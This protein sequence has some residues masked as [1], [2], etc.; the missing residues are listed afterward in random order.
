MEEILL[1]DPGTYPTNEVLENALGED[2]YKVFDKF[3]EIITESDL[4][5]TPEW[6]YYN[7]GKAWLC[8]VGFKKK[9]MFWLSIWK[10]HFKL[11]FYFTENNRSG[12]NELNIDPSIKEEF[13]QS[14]NIGKLIPLEIKMS[15]AE[16]IEDVIKIIGYKKSLK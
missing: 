11:G 6:K 3:I 7:D 14:K 5:L 8:K 10:M 2:N 1:R 12:V 9:T 16:Q 15:R 4:G 13:S